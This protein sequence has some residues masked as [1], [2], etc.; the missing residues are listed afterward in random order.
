[1]VGSIKNVYLHLLYIVFQVLYVEDALMM[2]CGKK[3]LSA[4]RKKLESY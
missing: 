4:L 2:I 3:C 1:M